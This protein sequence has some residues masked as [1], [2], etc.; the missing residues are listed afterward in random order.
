MA[1]VHPIPAWRHSSGGITLREPDRSQALRL[2][3]GRSVLERNE[4]GFETLHLPCGSCIGC[5]VSRAREW[6]VRC[7]L[8]F[9]QHDSACFVTLTYN[10]KHV[11]VTLRKAHLSGWIKRLRA[12]LYADDDER[13]IAAGKR[14]RGFPYRR[15]KFFACG[16]YG[17]ETARPHYHALLFGLPD[18]PPIHQAWTTPTLDAKGR[19]QY[20]D[21][22]LLTEPLGYVRVDP[23]TPET[24]AYV[25]G[26]VSKKFGLGELPGERVDYSTGEI[27]DYQPPFILMSRGGRTGN[28]IASAARVHWR[29]W[30]KSAI[31]HGRE[32]PVPR[33]LHEAFKQFAEPDEL[34]KLEAEKK[35]NRRRLTAYALEAAEKIASAK[36]A[37]KAERRHKL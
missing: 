1:C 5:R 15:F 28:G 35:E 17:E 6:A 33:Y 18:C 23:C 11:P 10:D 2:L 25:A 24:I 34:L 26:Y 37:L 36:L 32:V 8:E 30:R 14:K 12:R 7:W 20:L 19:R 16:E 13:R 29:S 27:Y 31:Y 22:I 3:E 21:G 9:Q 4:H